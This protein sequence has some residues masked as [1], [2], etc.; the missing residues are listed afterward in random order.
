L[1]VFMA[2]VVMN[3]MSS[4]YVNRFGLAQMYYILLSF[5]EIRRE[6]TDKIE[7]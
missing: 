7:E 6:P 3:I 1:A 2:V 4:S 5:V